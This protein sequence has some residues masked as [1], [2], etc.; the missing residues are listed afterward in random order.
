LVA[1]F[2][3]FGSSPGRDS[4]DRFIPTIAYQLSLSIPTTRQFIIKAIENNPLLPHASLWDQAKT[5]V[6]EPIRS[7]LST[8]SLATD[9]YPRIFV[10]DGLDECT[11]P[12]KQCEILQILVQLVQNLPVPFAFL[13]ASRPEIHITSSFNTGQLNNL[14]T[15]IFLGR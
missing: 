15:R 5:L 3:F 4:V 12:D 2:F 7:V 8:T 11:N 14:S 1:S 13:L 9:A 6:V 10:I